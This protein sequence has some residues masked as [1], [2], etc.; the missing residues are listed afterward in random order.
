MPEYSIFYNIWVKILFF[1]DLL[2]EL[3]RNAFRFLPGVGPIVYHNDKSLNGQLVII[4][5]A[6][7][8]IGK[9]TVFQLA[10]KQA[11][12]SLF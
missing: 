3:S 7:S 4:T 11:K 1:A 2:C 6:N 8:G 10:K 9:E 12:V 5:G